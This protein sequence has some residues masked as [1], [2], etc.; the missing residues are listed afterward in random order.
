MSAAL[1]DPVKEQVAAHWDRRAAHFDED[2]GHSIG[3]PAERAAW[4]RILDLVIPAG[5]PYD[6]LDAGCGTGFL[7]LELATRE[8]GSL[9]LE[10]FNAEYRRRIA[11]RR[12]RLVRGAQALLKSVDGWTAGEGPE[13]WDG[14]VRQAAEDLDS[15]AFLVERLGGTRYLDPTLVA[16]LYLIRRNLIEEHDA[17]TAAEHLM[18]DMVVLSYAQAIRINGWCGDLMAAIERELFGKAS[19][20]AKMPKRD[21]K[22]SRL[23]AEEMVQRLTAQLMPLLD[24]SNKMMLRNLA[25]LRHY[26]RPPATSLSIGQAQQVNVGGQQVNLAP[27]DQPASGGEDPKLPTARPRRRA[28]HRANTRDSEQE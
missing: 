3:S 17:R 11:E 27:A 24:R 1:S 2:F 15:G 22:D 4:D 10:K 26:R 6:A 25:A 12:E 5:G 23:L 28:A 14:R 7:A 8:D 16:V 19:L 13:G 9:D 20:P 21:G 18:I